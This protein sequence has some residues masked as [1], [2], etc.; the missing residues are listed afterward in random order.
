VFDAAGRCVLRCALQGPKVVLDVR[1]LPAGR[2][3][4]RLSNGNRSGS[5]A[6]VKK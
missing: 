3:L 1:Q 2:Y 6:F 4:L 5:R